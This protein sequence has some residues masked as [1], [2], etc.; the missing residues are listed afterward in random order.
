MSSAQR[1]TGDGTPVLQN[2]SRVAALAKGFAVTVDKLSKSEDNDVTEQIERITMPP[3]LF[4]L[5]INAQ[6]RPVVHELR[7]TK[8]VY[9]IR[10]MRLKWCRK[11]TNIWHWPLVR[12]ARPQPVR[13][14][15]SPKSCQQQRATNGLN[16]H[17]SRLPTPFLLPGSL[18]PSP[19]D[20]SCRFHGKKRLGGKRQPA[21]VALLGHDRLLCILA[22]TKMHEGQ[23]L[24]LSSKP[25]IG[26]LFQLFLGR[27]LQQALR[28]P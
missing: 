2:K 25:F 8:G 12:H 6:P 15:G 16:M 18:S 13:T 27:V 10:L 7:S 26:Q 20:P 23:P 1:V 5:A 28:P 19:R 24:T 14:A 9:L 4:E 22:W 17:P 3:R 11:G 21:A